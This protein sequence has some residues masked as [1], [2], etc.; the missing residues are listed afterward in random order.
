MALT[1]SQTIVQPS[2][3]TT[4]SIYQPFSATQPAL[5]TVVGSVNP[6]SSSGFAIQFQTS[7]LMLL[8]QSYV[9]GT[10]FSNTATYS[11]TTLAAFG[12]TAGTWASPVV[13]RSYTFTNGET[14]QILG[15]PEPSQLVLAAMGGIVLCVA[16]RW[17][18]RPR[19]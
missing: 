10:P 11:N 14:V 6:L 16:R 4:A 17:K 3:S 18:A 19:A 9:S 2:V 1:G 5:S 12:W 13:N 15:V 7:N 8:P